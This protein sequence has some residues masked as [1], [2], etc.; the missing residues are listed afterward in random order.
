MLRSRGTLEKDGNVN[1][2]SN[3]RHP[4]VLFQLSD[5]HT[6]SLSTPL[7]GVVLG[8]LDSK[9]EIVTSFEILKQDLFAGSDFLSNRLQLSKQV[10]PA[11]EMVGWY[12]I[13]ENYNSE[14]L[15]IHK[16]VS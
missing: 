8:T 3:S 12:C 16:G 14:F 13:N 7:F 4:L 11:L 15:S 9:V 2:I 1:E 10:S 5:A 6:R